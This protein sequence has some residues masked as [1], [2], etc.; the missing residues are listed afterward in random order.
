MQM[1]WTDVAFSIPGILIAAALTVE[2]LRRVRPGPF[3]QVASWALRPWAVWAVFNLFNRW[4]W[5][6]GFNQPFTF[7]FYADFWSG[8]GSPGAWL[9]PRLESPHFLLWGA[10]TLAAAAALLAL[11]WS[12]V[13]AGEGSRR[14]TALC[15]AVLLPLSFLFSWSL[16]QL[17]EGPQPDGKNPGSLLLPWHNASST[18]L[19]AMPLVKDSDD[20]LRNYPLLQSRLRI[21][22]HGLSHP[23]GAV[24]S[25]H[26][27]GCLAGAGENIR[28]NPVKL[29]YAA[30]LTAAGTLSVGAVFLLAASL[31]RSRRT[32]LL[33]AL[34]W[35]ASPALT[36]YVAFAQDVVYSLFFI[37]GLWL[38]WRVAKD[39]QPGVW[40]EIGLGLVFF[41]IAMLNY[42]WVL[43]TTI[44][45]VFI[46]YMTLRERRPWGS[47]AAR[48][49]LPLAVMTVAAGGVLLYYRLDYLAMYRAA[50]LY[51]D[52]WYRFTGPYQWG[53]AL[54]GGQIDLWVMMGSVVG[55]AFC[56]AV[57]LRRAP[58]GA[59]A[60]VFLAVLLLVYALPILLGPNPLK[61][62]T[63]RCWLWV[64]AAPCAFAAGE[65]LGHEKPMVLALG[66]V[67]VSLATS[68][69][70]RLFL[71]F[72][73]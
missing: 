1:A 59:P 13:R 36:A 24:L 14:R 10:V 16:N 8:R 38:A 12:V 34:L 46:L 50:R 42:S 35:A 56:A 66:A 41:A 29:R 70:L 51:V 21:T 68:V 32:G 30:G 5:R 25:L 73:V 63:S 71:N 17:P 23:P 52:E 27:I 26:Y 47:L 61:M 62:E 33:A 9:L 64:A 22:T 40:K 15:L 37:L 57:F 44:F 7:P 65:L 58:A 19:Y 69:T 28:S 2:I 18:L 45:T 20:F 53:M 67:L 48:W 11:A 72:G 49:A 55:S 3:P 60:R 31:F 54:V 4:Q 6:K 39:P 43:M